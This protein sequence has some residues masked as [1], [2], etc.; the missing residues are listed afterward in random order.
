MENIRR[1]AVVFEGA[2]MQMGVRIISLIN[3][4]P[5]RCK[6]KFCKMVLHVWHRG[7]EQSSLYARVWALT[8][9]RS[10][11]VQVRVRKLHP[12]FCRHH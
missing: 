1:D 8:G 3:N 5:V 7:Q 2:Q 9:M 11:T 12:M 6:V 10:C 4:K